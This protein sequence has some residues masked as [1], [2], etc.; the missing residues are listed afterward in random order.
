MNDPI[1]IRPATAD[2]SAAVL[3][4]SALDDRRPP[5]GQTMLAFVDGELL[6]ARPVDGAEPV[7]DPFR[8][9]SHLIAMLE[10]QSRADHGR[11]A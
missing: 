10:L 3:R 6:A 9:T 4:L 8:R 5:K 7:A 2:D 11:A 1:T